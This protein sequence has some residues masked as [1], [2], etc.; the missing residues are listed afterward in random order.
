MNDIDFGKENWKKEYDGTVTFTF[1]INN[2]KCES[3]IQITRWYYELSFNNVTIEYNESFVTF[4]YQKNK[5]N[6]LNKIKYG[7]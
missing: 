1:D 4:D 7:L 6:I 5:S 3:S 2:V